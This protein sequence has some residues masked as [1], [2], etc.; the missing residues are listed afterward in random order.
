MYPFG[1]L[2]RRLRVLRYADGSIRA[3]RAP[4]DDALE[5]MTDDVR[6]F[7]AAQD[8][9]WRLARGGTIEDEHDREKVEARLRRRMG[10]R[11]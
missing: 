6:A 1:P 7:F 11:R 3:I 9:A 10:F 2:H 8:K 4:G 5:W